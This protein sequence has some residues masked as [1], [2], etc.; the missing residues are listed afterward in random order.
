MV[1]TSWLGPPSWPP[2]SPHYVPS[3]AGTSVSG[4]LTGPQAPPSW[5]ERGPAVCP[6]V[7]PLSRG[8]E[9]AGMWGGP[10]T[11]PGP[12]VLPL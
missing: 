8:G 11:I 2:P 5:R 6:P 10:L 1:V 3:G 9:R 7:T 12:Q 4:L